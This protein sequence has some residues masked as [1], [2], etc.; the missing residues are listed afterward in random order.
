MILDIMMT[1]WECLVFSCFHPT[2]FAFALYFC[3]VHTYLQNIVGPSCGFVI[4]TAFSLFHPSLPPTLGLLTY[5]SRP[6]N[7]QLLTSK[8][9]I[10]SLSIYNSH[11]LALSTA[12]FFPLASIQLSACGLVIFV[13]QFS[14][15]Q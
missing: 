7:L 8:P 14:I 1:G 5:N 4:T 6:L 11:Y 10:L 2:P 9:I 13:A 3:L 12:W 15:L